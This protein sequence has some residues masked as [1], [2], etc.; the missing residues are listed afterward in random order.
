[1]SGLHSPP[2]DSNGSRGGGG[3]GGGGGG[4]GGKGGARRDAAWTA[5]TSGGGIR[6][7]S[8][9][10]AVAATAAVFARW[11]WTWGRYPL[12][13]L[14]AT[15]GPN[16]GLGTAAS[17]NKESAEPLGTGGPGDPGGVGVRG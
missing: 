9:V 5:C 3:G 14:E 4:R 11:V 13:A 7:A 10:V 12:G 6:S 16:E 1:M 2:P 17:L 8:E 15:A